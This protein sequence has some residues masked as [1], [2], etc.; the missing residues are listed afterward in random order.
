MIG[1]DS[2]TA[3]AG[4]KIISRWPTMNAAISRYE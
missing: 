2:T 4:W 3:L 1:R